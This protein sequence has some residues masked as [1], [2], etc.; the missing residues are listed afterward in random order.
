MKGITI[1]TDKN[2]LDVSLIHEFLTNSYWAEGR[3]F[4]QVKTSIENSLCWGIYLNNEQIGF[5][6]VLTD[7]SVV[8]YLM[9]VFIIEKYRG[10]GYSKILLDE[11][12]AHKDLQSIGKWILATKDAHDLYRQFGFKEIANPER[13]MSRSSKN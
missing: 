2:K 3:T 1:S 10:N 4:E 5:A 9:D 7:G 12:L 13:L 11:I 8:A 6:R